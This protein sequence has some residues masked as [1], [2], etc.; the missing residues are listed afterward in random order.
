MK[1][2]VTW[3]ITSIIAVSSFMSPIL[4]AIINNRHNR[5]LH[6][7]DLEY[8]SMQSQLSAIY[9]NKEAAFS[10]FIQDAGKACIDTGHPDV[11]LNFFASSQ[12]VLLYA[13][14]ENREIIAKFIQDVALLLDDSYAN[15][16]R[17]YELEQQLSKI[18]ILLNQ[19]LTTL[20][21][22]IY[23]SPNRK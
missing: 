14:E 17:C 23:N 18:A 5:K 4:V 1:L 3:T 2:D 11:E 9:K 21:R 15:E 20:H 13:S 22:D 16:A 7:M 8:N 19:E 6:K 10:S 12:T